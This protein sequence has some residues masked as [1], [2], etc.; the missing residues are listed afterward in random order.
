MSTC[1]NCG[2]EFDSNYCPNCGQKATAGERFTLK[3]Y[4]SNS[5]VSFAR[6]NDG[7]AHTAIG[8]VR[9]PWRVIA[10]YIHGKRVNYSPPFTMLIQV[11]L[12]TSVIVYMLEHIFGVDLFFNDTP[13]LT[14]DVGNWFVDFV[15]SSDIFQTSI[16]IIPASLAGIIAFRWVGGRRYNA[17]EYLVAGTYMMCLNFIARFMIVPIQLFTDGDTYG[18]NQIF[19]L[20]IILVTL[21][22]A[23]AGGNWWCRVLSILF[24]LVLAVIFILIGFTLLALIAIG[25]SYLYGDGFMIGFNIH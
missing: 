10:D 19:M 22:K 24:Y 1:K 21:W 16:M 25:I 3:A 11:I 4:T 14:I 2:T 5:L 13:Y 17:A 18:I 20:A 9:H 6:L 15:L 12:Y 8:L 23:F 7:F